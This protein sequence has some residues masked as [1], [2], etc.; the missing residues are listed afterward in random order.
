MLARGYLETFVICMKV[1]IDYVFR[2]WLVE[3]MD[4]NIVLVNYIY[5]TLKA[6]KFVIFKEQY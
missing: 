1:E 5:I 2:F 4:L 6:V 3:I